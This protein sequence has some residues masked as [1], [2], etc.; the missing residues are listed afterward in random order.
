MLRRQGY[1]VDCNHRDVDVE[2]ARWTAATGDDA[3]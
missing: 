3:E 2:Q 1:H